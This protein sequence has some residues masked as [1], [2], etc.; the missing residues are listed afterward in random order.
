M[1]TA[2][3][4]IRD[5]SKAHIRYHLKD[6]TI[7]PGV[8]TFTGVLE[9]WGM[10][11]K[12]NQ[13]GLQGIK[14]REYWK[15]LANIGTITHRMILAD[16]QGEDPSAC[17]EDET[18]ADVSLAENCFLSY[19]SWK[20]GKVIE[21]I[22][23][24]FPLVSEKFRFGGTLDFY[25]RIDRV[26]TLAD[27]KTGAAIYDENWYQLASLS[28]LLAEAEYEAPQAFTVINI[29]RAESDAFDAKTRTGLGAEWQI[30][31]KLL[32]IYYLRK[33]GTK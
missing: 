27:F 6:N 16:L 10:V 4:T 23:L 28:V 8:T 32:E 24:E 31:K 22:L 15:S 17:I 21:P 18:K 13:L 2:E 12:A 5:K 11:D 20:S 9:K 26:L 29:P 25:G 1:T 14:S 7:V 3:Q 33:E 19:L 30:S